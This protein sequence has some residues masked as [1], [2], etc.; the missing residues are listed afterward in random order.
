M[1]CTMLGFLDFF[2]FFLKKY[3]VLFDVVDIFDVVD[4]DFVYVVRDAA[5][6]AD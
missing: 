3:W 5:D 6:D 2:V 1:A 4:D